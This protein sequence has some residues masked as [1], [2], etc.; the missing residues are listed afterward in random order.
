MRLVW[1]LLL[2]AVAAAA[3]GDGGH[4]RR[5]ARSPRPSMQELVPVQ[6]DAEQQLTG[7]EVAAQRQWA[8]H[9]MQLQPP[10]A[11]TLSRS[12]SVVFNCADPQ[13][14]LSVP[15]CVVLLVLLTVVFKAAATSGGGGCPEKHMHVLDNAR[16][17]SMFLVVFG[18]W[19]LPKRLAIAWVDQ[20]VH[21]HWAGSWVWISWRQLHSIL[22][23]ASSAMISGMVSQSPATRKRLRSVFVQILLPAILFSALLRPLEQAV[24][25]LVLR[26]RGGRAHPP[27]DGNLAALWLWW[28]PTF[29]G[30]GI[31]WFLWCLVAWRLAGFVLLEL[32]ARL[33]L[34]QWAALGF[35]VPLLVAA[36]FITPPWASVN[37]EE[38]L[39]CGLAMWPIFLAGWLTPIGA[40]LRIVPP[41][42]PLRLVGAVGLVLW[43]AAPRGPPPVRRGLQTWQWLPFEEQPDVGPILESGCFWDI[44]FVW[45]R[46]LFKCLTLVVVLLVFF[47]TLCPREEHWFTPYGRHT[48]YIYL[49]Q[50]PA[51]VVLDEVAKLLPQPT[52]MRGHPV[53]L[54]A[55]VALVSIAASAALTI[56][57][58]SKPVRW[59]TAFIIQPEWLGNL[60]LGK[61]LQE[62]REREALPKEP[63]RPADGAC[64]ATELQ[65][66]AAPEARWA[67][68]L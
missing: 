6:L 20:G 15:G 30:A 29:W 51:I 8:N 16:L 58:A 11:N 67:A 17:F 66:L 36:P 53:L 27:W 43:I 34:P 48:M 5:D 38:L 18:H 54:M 10:A 57:L 9:T 50:I 21:L 19:H 65:P 1:C 33:Q 46:G 52:P 28:W 56:F 37:Y 22:A 32:N 39:S 13:T 40:L 62:G 35:A 60:L 49:L 61:E 26:L 45:T 64:C 47:L 55:L 44:A 42:W 68:P 23:M 2:R 24:P 31:A 59:A 25:R 12:V 3:D 63:P 41:S 4:L 7:K 14:E